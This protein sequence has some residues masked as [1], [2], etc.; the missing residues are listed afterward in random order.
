[1]SIGAFVKRVYH[2]LV[3]LAVRR[4]LR[5]SR[6]SAPRR[7]R[8]A[9]WRRTGG[10]VAAGPLKGLRLAGDV[11]DDCFGAALLGAYECETHEWLEEQVGK[12]WPHVV[13]IGSSEGYY[14]VGLALRLP[15]ATVHAFEMDAALREVGDE[16][17][18]RNGVRNVVSHGTATP[19]VLAALPIERALV[20][21]DCE[22]AEQELIDP[23][24]VPW[25]MHSA[26]LVELH[27]VPAP[28]IED[29]LRRRFART[30]DISIATQRPR[31]AAEWARKTQVSLDDARIL[32]AELRPQDGVHVDSSWMLLTPRLEVAEPQTR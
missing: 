11:P 29:T 23:A 8:A 26:L 21:S 3:P 10:R 4:R 24:S 14:S 5:V 17:A 22:G 7:A 2:A 13:N 6:F 16:A 12:G 28:G 25:M 32:L 9:L 20:L 30:H 15:G 1:M 18:R 19:S 27:D 31:D